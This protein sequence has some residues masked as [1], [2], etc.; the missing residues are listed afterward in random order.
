MKKLLL[1]SLLATL[2]ACASS[3]QSEGI[4]SVILTRAGGFSGLEDRYVIE[5]TGHAVKTMRF[6]KEDE[7][8]VIDTVLPMSV[9]NPIF[10]FV[11]RNIDSLRAIHFDKTGNMTTTLILN[12]A[13]TS[14]DSRDTRG[15]A[16]YLIRWPNLE[17]PLLSTNKLDSMYA[18]VAPVE[19]WLSSSQ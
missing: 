11:D 12:A 1:L 2:A 15:P 19:Q 9:V 3:R 17:P 14:L 10:S 16:S 8:V 6:P 18:L 7:R 13:A 5:R 4:G